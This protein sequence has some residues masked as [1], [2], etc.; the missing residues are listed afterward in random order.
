MILNEA[1]LFRFGCA[2]EDGAERMKSVSELPAVFVLWVVRADALASSAAD[3]PTWSQTCLETA[4][5]FVLACFGHVS[6]QFKQG[7]V[8]IT[9]YSRGPRVG[10]W[11]I[12]VSVAD[13]GVGWGGV[14]WGG[15]GSSGVE[16]N[17]V[18]WGG[19]GTCFT[20]RCKTT[21]H[22]NRFMVQVL[23]LCW[24]LEMALLLFSLFGAASVCTSVGAASRRVSFATAPRFRAV[25]RPT[26]CCGVSVLCATPF[27]CLSLCR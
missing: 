16:W 14:G 17:G 24:R 11:G 19:V 18:E 21:G 22:G 26:F 25:R 9:W 12:S 1:F 23:W 2:G 3:D 6:N 27:A 8:P 20:L 5:T 7:K 15:V 13:R 4:W 10:I